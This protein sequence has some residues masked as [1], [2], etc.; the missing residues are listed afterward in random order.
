MYKVCR[1]Q[2]EQLNLRYSWVIHIKNRLSN[3]GLLNAREQ[4]GN[5]LTNDYAKTLFRSRIEN[6]YQHNWLESKSTHSH[7][8]FYDQI[9]RDFKLEKYLITLDYGLRIALTKFRCRNNCIPISKSRF[10][11]EGMEDELLLCP[12]CHESELCDEYHY[13]FVCPFFLSLL[14]CLCCSRII[15]IGLVAFCSFLYL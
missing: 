7:C 10:S 15:S 4:N 2:V 9:K 12:L 14:M 13:L 11:D 5:G 8:V 6:L 1:R 3:I